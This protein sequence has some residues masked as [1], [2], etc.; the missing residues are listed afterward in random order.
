MTENNLHALNQVAT[1]NI[2]PENLDVSRAE[3]TMYTKHFRQEINATVCSVKYQSEQ[4]HCVF[5]D[6]S[7]MHAHHTG[8]ITKELTVTASQCRTSAKGGSI[9]LKDETL[10]FKK[11]I[12]TTVVKHKDFDDDGADLSDKYRNE[13]NSYGWVIRKTF[14][15]HVKDVVPKLRTKD[16]KILSK[17]GLQLPCPLEELGC[18]TTSIDTYAYTW[19]VRD[20][21]ALAIHRKEDVNMIKEGKNNYY[22]VSGRNNTNQYLFEVKTNPEV[23]CNKPV[24]VYPTNYDSLYEVIHFVG[25][26]LASEKKMGYSG[27]TQNLQYCQPAVSSDGKLFVD[28][29]ESPH[30]DNPIPDTPH[31]F[32]L[33]YKLHQG[34]KLDYLF[35]ASSNMLKGSEIQLLKNLCEQ[36][37]TQIMSILMLSMENPRL[38]GYILTGNRSMFL[39]TNGSLAWLYHCPLMRSPSHVMNQCYDKIPIF[40][41]NAIFFVD[42]ITRQTYP[43]AQVQNCSDRIKN[44]FQFDMDDGN[45]WLTSTPT[46]ER[47][48][49][50]SSIWTKRCHSCFQKSFWWSRRCGSLHTSTVIWNMEFILISAASRKALQNFSRELIV[51]NTA[52]HGPE[53][54]SYYAPRTDFYVDNMISPSH[55]KNQFM[56]T[57]GSVAYVLEFCGKDFS[58]FLF[59]KLI[60]DLIA[61]IL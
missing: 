59:I 40:Y 5:G 27:G 28:K 32:N 52:I 41:K 53:Q 43:V 24:Q 48:E 57:F 26:D 10:E 1:C 35:F 22:I 23:F 30:T 55:F 12:K 50:T 20:D 38:A 49:T 9:T 16:G 47:Q 34:T 46:L 39:S 7:S 6:D 36:E 21:C 19:D 14:E 42:P 31:Y 60:I 56:D 45:S 61:M 44:L 37:R 11:G 51:P 18:D 2:A 3:I 17:D 4:C 54:Y 58:C 8:G 29:P 13:C 15:C 33:D 25:L